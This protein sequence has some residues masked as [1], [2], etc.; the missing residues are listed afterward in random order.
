MQNEIDPFPTETPDSSGSVRT[1]I[2]RNILDVI[3][4]VVFALLIFAVINT[5]TARIR[6]DGM[7][8]EP[9]LETGE[10]VIINKLAYRLGTPE[11]GDV[12][13]FHFPRNPEQEYIK[14][15]IG[16]A[17]DQVV[18]S[19][20]Q[21]EVNGRVLNEPY[22]AAPPRYELSEVVPEDSLFVLGDNRNNSSDSHDWG[23]VPMAN[24]VG[25]AV[26]IY[27]PVDQWGA[28]KHVNPSGGDP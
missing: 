17:G 4:T 19:N 12:I 9:T 15:V 23:A 14:R 6:V 28:I 3:E 24:V 25:K 27:W 5:L 1:R 10:F 7:S 13:V 2:L 21:V 18:I 8:M 16:L 20:R 26:F 22:I 11:I